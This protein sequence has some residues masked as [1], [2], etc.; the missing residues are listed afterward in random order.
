MDEA[1]A[2]DARNRRQVDHQRRGRQHQR[3]PVTGPQRRIRQR[4]V[5]AIEPVA[6]KAFAGERADYAD[7]GELVAHHPVDGVDQALHAAEQRQHV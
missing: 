5:D 7:T 3:L 1:L 2:D 6:L 4:D